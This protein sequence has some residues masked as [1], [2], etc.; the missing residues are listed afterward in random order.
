MK[1]ALTLVSN[2]TPSAAA[3]QLAS[4]SARETRPETQ[5][6]WGYRH[7]NR[8]LASHYLLEPLAS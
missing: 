1:L 5:E 4:T 8:W 7:G 2:S 3:G 6:I